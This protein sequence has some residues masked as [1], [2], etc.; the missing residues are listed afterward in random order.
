MQGEA[1]AVQSRRSLRRRWP[2]R[3]ET[4]PPCAARAA[5]HSP[6]ST[7]RRTS[8]ARDIG[9][10][11]VAPGPAA[12]SRS[13]WQFDRHLEAM[14]APLQ[15]A[16]GSDQNVNYRYVG[17]RA[18]YLLGRRR[19]VSA[20]F[21]TQTTCGAQRPSSP[22][23]PAVGCLIEVGRSAFRTDASRSSAARDSGLAPPRP[24]RVVQPAGKPACQWRGWPA[25]RT[26]LRREW[27]V[28]IRRT[29]RAAGP[30]RRIGDRQSRAKVRAVL[31]PRRSPAVRSLAARGVMNAS[32]SVSACAHA[33]GGG[34]I[35]L[36]DRT[37]RHGARL[38]LCSASRVNSM[39]LVGDSAAHDAPRP[40]TTARGRGTRRDPPDRSGG[41]IFLGRRQGGVDGPRLASVVAMVDGIGSSESPAQRSPVTTRP[42]SQRPGA[43][44]DVCGQGETMV[45]D[46]DLGRS[47]R[48]PGIRRP[49]ATRGR[50]PPVLH[51]KT[52]KNHPPQQKQQ[53][54]NHGSGS[55][56]AHVRGIDGGVGRYPAT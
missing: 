51:T 52:K 3:A 44:T 35:V 38:D 28:A 54:K 12:T 15:D 34:K 8:F 23:L 20:S 42:G 39:N 19:R 47:S 53:P 37:R 26:S 30:R 14:C 33:V 56:R 17:R 46:D 32:G 55:K 2:S 22:P 29:H 10:Q 31:P 21:V 49:L 50:L 9:W 1:V 27:A 25:T 7:D 6:S 18:R 48:G 36:Y 45:F 5:H 4:S 11:S 40:L 24:L 41:R 16:R 43:V 13:T